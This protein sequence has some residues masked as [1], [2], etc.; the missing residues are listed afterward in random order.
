MGEPSGVKTI[1]EQ[2]IKEAEKQGD[3]QKAERFRERLNVIK[4]KHNNQLVK[5][6]ASQSSNNQPQD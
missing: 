2:K 3:I 4:F 5:N 1:Y 6:L